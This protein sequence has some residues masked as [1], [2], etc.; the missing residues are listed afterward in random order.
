MIKFKKILLILFFS[1]LFLNKSFS[2]NDDDIYKKIDLFSEVLETIQNEYVE[3]IDIAEA[4][5]SAINGLL[6]S[7]DPYSAYMN[8]NIFD[9][10][11]TEQ[12]GNL[13]D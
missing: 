1:I 7:L 3:D 13:E 8:Q 12:V 9:E 6:Q 2:A 5:D 10:S 11:Q 4:M